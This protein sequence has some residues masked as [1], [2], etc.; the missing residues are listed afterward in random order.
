[1]YTIDGQD[2]AVPIEDIPR[3]ALPPNPL[4]V[5]GDF[6][7]FLA[8]QVA[9]GTG[10]VL[11]EFENPA[12]HYFGGPSDQALNGHP[13]RG[14]G[15]DYYGAFEVY[16]SSW[17]RVLARMDRAHPRHDPRMFDGLRHFI[18]TFQDETF[19]CVARGMRI[20]SLG[21]NNAENTKAI[22]DTMFARVG[23]PLG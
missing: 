21:A 2:Q 6:D 20:L 18:F 11:I 14:R 9:P 7:L 17:I 19:E 8:Y 15:L 12:S 5:A 23:R 3:P 16:D 4:V 1:M 10:L 13:L 22:F